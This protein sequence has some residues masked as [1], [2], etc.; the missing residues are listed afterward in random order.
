MKLF[1]MLLLCVLSLTL[2]AQPATAPSH[3]EMNKLSFLVGKW[4]GEGW[5]MQGQGQRRNCTITETV[6]SKLDGKAFVIEG[7]GKGKDADNLGK[8]IHHAFAVL[9][10]DQESKIFRLR[11]ILADGR[12]VDDEP[13]MPAA[14]TFVWGFKIP[15]GQV[16]FTIKLNEKGQWFEIGEFSRDGQTWMKTLEMTLNRVH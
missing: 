8:T 4:Q 9:S 11:A 12:T 14:N 3:N 10:Y 2:A 15:Y 7:I 6:E 13:K 1:T 5:I 16:R